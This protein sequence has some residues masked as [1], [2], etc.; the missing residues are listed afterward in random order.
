MVSHNMWS[1]VRSKR[2]PHMEHY[3]VVRQW[4]DPN[5][6]IASWP[7]DVVKILSR[8]I[9]L[10]KVDEVIK[11]QG[12]YCSVSPN[13]TNILYSS[14]EKKFQPIFSDLFFLLV[15]YYATSKSYI[16]L[17]TLYTHVKLRS[18]HLLYSLCVSIICA[19]LF[20]FFFRLCISKK[21]PPLTY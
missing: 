15:P 5:P 16:Y 19:I 21:T 14:S 18:S 20:L 9:C 3:H 11:R 8:R 12:I 17:T 7:G 6:P 1:Y 2:T 4:K 10:T 13:N